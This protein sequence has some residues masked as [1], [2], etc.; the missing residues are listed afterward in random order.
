MMRG[1]EGYF[2]KEL[3]GTLEALLQNSRRQTFTVVL[4]A[5]LGSAPYL[6]TFT[7]S[8][9]MCPTDA[10]TEVDLEGETPLEI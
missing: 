8:V 10:T 1:T 6:K 3:A 5:W 4:C 2:V 9:A 7:I